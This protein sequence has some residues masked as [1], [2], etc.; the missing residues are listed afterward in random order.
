MS[1]EKDLSDNTVVQ[2]AIGVAMG[3][4]A[5]QVSDQATL[6][7]AG[8][9][10]LMYRVAHQLGFAEV[11]LS[12]HSS[13]AKSKAGSSAGGSKSSGRGASSQCDHSA[14]FLQELVEDNR[15]LILGILGGFGLAKIQLSNSLSQVEH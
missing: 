13:H 12:R 1:Y 2:A 9:G 5:A 7:A 6:V 4:V 11:N 14:A 10:L 15:C 8:T 3:Y